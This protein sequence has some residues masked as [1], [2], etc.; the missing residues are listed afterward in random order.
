[1]KYGIICL[2][3]TLLACTFEQN[4]PLLIGEWTLLEWKITST[5]EQRTGYKMDFTFSDDDTY[6]VDYGSEKEL[7]K[8][9]ISGNNLY[10]T[11]QGMAR[12]MVRITQPVNDT[13]QF[14]MNRSGQLELIT[15]I[16]KE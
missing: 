14:E 12:K 8:W 4:K 7:G 13:L 5:G 9:S 1:M 10:T 2:L 6:S 15:L 16:R 11:E 3:I